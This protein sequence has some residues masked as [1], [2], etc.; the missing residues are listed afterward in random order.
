LAEPY[1]GEIKAPTLLEFK[2]TKEKHEANIV[3]GSTLY[4]HHKKK[5]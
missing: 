3:T 2:A 4:N 5:N 1:D